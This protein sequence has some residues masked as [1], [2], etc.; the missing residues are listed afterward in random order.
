MLYAIVRYFN[1]SGHTVAEYAIDP[2]F[3]PDAAIDAEYL[4]GRTVV[5]TYPD[6]WYTPDS[7]YYYAS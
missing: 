6:Y 3:Y 4:D 2:A 1:T 5:I 7:P